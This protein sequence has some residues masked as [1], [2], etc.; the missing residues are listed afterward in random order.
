MGRV[1]T[2]ALF[3]VLSSSMPDSVAIHH[4]RN[5]PLRICRSILPVA[6]FN[7]AIW[8]HF[9]F[10]YS[11]RL[12]LCNTKYKYY[13][14][15]YIP[16]RI[17]YISTTYFFVFSLLLSL[18]YVIT[19]YDKRKLSEKWGII[20]IFRVKWF[21][22]VCDWYIIAMKIGNS[23]YRRLVRLNAEEKSTLATKGTDSCVQP[24]VSVPYNCVASLG[25][26]IA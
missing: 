5:P 9:P 21:T 13:S 26:G 12:L 22:F 4:I 15:M 8:R 10:R 7:D 24:A 14:R 18:L 17:L 19:L 1:A 16:I 3:F 25:K 2:A 20:H 23:H 6:L 11:L